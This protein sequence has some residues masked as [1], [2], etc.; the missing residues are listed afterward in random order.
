MCVEAAVPI[1]IGVAH[2]DRLLTCQC[3]TAVIHTTNAFHIVA[4]HT[5]RREIIVLVGVD[6]VEGEVLGDAPIA[7]DVP[8][9]TNGER[10][11]TVAK[12]V[13]VVAVTI[14]EN[15]YRVGE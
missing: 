8:L 9:R 4:W 6:K 14:A 15:G 1:E 5:I 10:D 3:R 7:V 2:D 13:L 12:I 11:G